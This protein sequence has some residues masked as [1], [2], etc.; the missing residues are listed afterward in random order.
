LRIR[1]DGSGGALLIDYTTTATSID[2]YWIL[3]ETVTLAGVVTAFLNGSLIGSTA[4]LGTILGLAATAYI[5]VH[6]GLTNYGISKPLL[7]AL[8]DGAFTAKQ[9]LAYSR[10][11]KN[12]FN[13]PITI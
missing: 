5:G 10:Y 12:V 1:A 9:A 11:L 3:I 4:G 7:V 8:I 13:L 6:S 2:D